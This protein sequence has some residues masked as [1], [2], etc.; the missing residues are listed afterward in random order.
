M[1][2]SRQNLSHERPLRWRICYLALPYHL[3]EQVEWFRRQFFGHKTEKLVAPLAIS[4]DLFGKLPDAA[5]SSIEVTAHQRQALP[6]VVGHGR[7]PLPEDLLRKEI[8]L[9]IPESE[10]TCPAAARSGC[11]S[12]KMGHAGACSRWNA[13]GRVLPAFRQ[14]RYNGKIAQS[15]VSER[16]DIEGITEHLRRISPA[17]LVPMAPRGAAKPRSARALRLSTR[18]RSGPME[19]CRAGDRPFQ[20]SLGPDERG[21][22]HRPRRGR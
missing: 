8:V 2:P 3:R 9:D 22:G 13:R 16:R 4:D 17:S 20:A 6:K 18:R 19:P 7:A 11:A 5:A 21:V 15:S 1:T 10:K 12:E 14:P